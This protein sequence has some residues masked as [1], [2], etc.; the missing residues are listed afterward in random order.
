MNSSLKRVHGHV[1]GDLNIDIE[2]WSI[3]RKIDFA[4]Y[5]QKT[6]PS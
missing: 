3:R 1:S 6:K 5:V 2:Y 4:E